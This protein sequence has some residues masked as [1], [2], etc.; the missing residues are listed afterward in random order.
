MSK[1]RGRPRLEYV[2]DPRNPVYRARK[3]L[4]DGKSEFEA[5]MAR[6]WQERSLSLQMDLYRT[7]I[8][9]LD[10]G[11]TVAELCRMYRTTSRN[12]VYDLIERAKAAHGIGVTSAGDTARV[13]PLP[14]A[15]NPEGYPDPY[16]VTLPD[17]VTAIVYVDGGEAKM[18]DS[19][20]LDY[21]HDLM[22]KTGP[23]WDALVQAG[24]IAQ[25]KEA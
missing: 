19:P 11:T 8:E 10:K 25:D 23:V 15:E 4:E 9:E 14:E 7:L 1:K 12:T 3:A 13:E 6:L 20:G 17:G 18:L 16:K 22:D 2:F 21:T 5:E 24:V